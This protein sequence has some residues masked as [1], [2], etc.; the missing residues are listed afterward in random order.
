[1]VNADISCGQDFLENDPL[2]GSMD[3]L[4]VK[5]KTLQEGFSVKDASII[6]LFCLFSEKQLQSTHNN[7]CLVLVLEKVA[8]SSC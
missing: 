3:T 4:R 6:V 7:E 8:L 5:T 1:M 2:S